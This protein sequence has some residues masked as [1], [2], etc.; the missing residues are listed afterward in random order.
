MQRLSSALRRISLPSHARRHAHHQHAHQRASAA[1]AIAPHELRW[2][3][4]H[5]QETT[6][7]SSAAQDK[8]GAE[9]RVRRLAARR[10]AG[11]PLQYVLGGAWAGPLQLR[12]RRGVLI[13]RECTAD[14]V[15]LLMARLARASEWDGRGEGGRRGRALRVLDLCAGSGVAALLAAYALPPLAAPPAAT[16]ALGRGGGLA[17]AAVDVDPRALLL[18]RVNRRAVLAQLAASR[19]RRCGGGAAR[20]ALEGMAFVRAD[21]FAADA[22]ARVAAG[23]GHAG[24]WDA[25]VC[26]PPYISPRAFHATTAASVREYEPHSAL[27]PPAAPG[28]DDV[29]QGDRFY[30]R[31]LQLADAFRTSVVLFEVADMAQAERVG[32][33]ARQLRWSGVEIWRDDPRERSGAEVYRDVTKTGIRVIG[34]GEGRSVLCYRNKARSWLSSGL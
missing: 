3:R 7:A 2:I 32:G 9:A 17:V 33:M 31:V 26:N 24:P 30:P 6:R 20:A 19:E 28:L 1:A 27:V 11:V 10:A 14:A 8:D 22:P 18:A 21:V 15:G 5:V 16:P 29:A 13:P 4:E 12:C 23:T 25:I 34:Q